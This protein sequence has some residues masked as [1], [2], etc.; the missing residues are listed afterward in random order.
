MK[1]LIDECLSARL[2]NVVKYH[3]PESATLSDLGLAGQ[4]DWEIAKYAV[5]HDWVVVTHNSKDMRGK[6]YKG[7]YFA[8]EKIHPGMISLYA[9]DHRKKS[10]IAMN[11]RMQNSL[12]VT[13]LEYIKENEQYELLNHALEIDFDG[14]E[15]NIRLYEAPPY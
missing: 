9:Y 13:A 6:N 14:Y 15:V 2:V 7:G 3:G 12:F 1:F 8:K 5:A 10:P 4:K 11:E